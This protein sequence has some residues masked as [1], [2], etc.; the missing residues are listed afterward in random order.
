[1]L[2]QQSFSKTQWRGQSKTEGVLKCKACLKKQLEEH[3]KK[4]KEREE[5]AKAAAAAAGEGTTEETPA[6]G[7]AEDAATGG[8]EAGADNE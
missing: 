3:L 5:A 1:M 8:E 4:K 6:N 7:D 2:R